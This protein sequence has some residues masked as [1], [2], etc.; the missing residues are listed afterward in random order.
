MGVLSKLKTTIFGKQKPERSS[1]QP[2][3]PRSKS[4]RIMYV[5]IHEN[6]STQ[7]FWSR[8]SAFEYA[9]R[10]AKNENMMVYEVNA[11]HYDLNIGDTPSRGQYGV[12]RIWNFSKQ[13]RGMR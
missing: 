6:D 2:K 8:N 11:H 12:Y 7:N 10:E 4:H 13:K 3:K 5:V 1:G 9:R